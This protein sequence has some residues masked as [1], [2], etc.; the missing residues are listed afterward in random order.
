MHAAISSRSRA[1]SGV[2]S[3]SVC[4]IRYSMTAG[5]PA[6][7]G[8]VP[9]AAKYSTPPRENTSLAGPAGWPWAC[10]GDMN[11][12]VPSRL[13][14]E[15][16]TVPSSARAMPK[17]ITRG[18]SSASSTLPGFRSRCTSP[19]SWMTRSAS[20]SPAASFSTASSGSGPA[21]VTTSCSD[22]PA[23]YAMASQG[24]SSSGP[25]STTGAA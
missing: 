18:P 2:R 13:S 14:A 17:S 5:C 8:G 9:V 15:V 23:T 24:G 11:D 16:S 4:T 22:G 21:A 3:G 20:A 12:G 7:N 25:A 6:P 10:S 19:Q 1:G